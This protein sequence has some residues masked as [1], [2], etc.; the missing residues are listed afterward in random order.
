MK[1]GGGYDDHPFVAEFYDQVIPHLIRNDIRHYTTLAMAADGPVMELACGTGR[2]LLPMARAGVDV[3]GLD[4]SRPMLERCSRR[5]AQEAIDTRRRARLFYGD[6]R[7]FALRRKFNLAIIA[8]RSF[9]HLPTVDDQRRCLATIHHHLEP[10]GRLALDLFNPN[11][12][13]LVAGDGKE[14]GSEPGFEMEDG[15]RVCRKHRVVAHD[16][17][18]QILDTEIIYYVE[19]EGGETER[20]VHPFSMRYLFPYEAEHLLARA[21]FALESRHA[22]FDGTP[23]GDK[24]PGDLVL[25]ARKRG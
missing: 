19:R 21:G 14:F 12:D 22:D 8:F 13:T 16:H 18:A 4:F 5:L 3:T 7:S 10:E 15:R 9:Q 11:L 24:Y 6:M 20:L 1:Q 17:A 23:F 25:V 2:L